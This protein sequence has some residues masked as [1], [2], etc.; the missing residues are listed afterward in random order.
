M[1]DSDIRYG[2][3]VRQGKTPPLHCF[4][5]GAVQGTRD[6]DSVTIFMYGPEGMAPLH[7]TRKDVRDNWEAA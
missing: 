4:M 6:E 2:Q 1:K 7:R 3:T 5:I